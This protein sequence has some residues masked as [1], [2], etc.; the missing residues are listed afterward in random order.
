[1]TR[2]DTKYDDYFES[3]N[4]LIQSKNVLDDPKISFTRSFIWASF[5]LIAI[6]RKLKKREV[7]VACYGGE[8]WT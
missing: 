5:H 4:K 8:G 1:M 6:E 2:K 7:F 3:W